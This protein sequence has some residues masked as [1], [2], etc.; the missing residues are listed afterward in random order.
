MTVDKPLMD[1]NKG[2]GNDDSFEAIFA[3]NMGDFVT[4]HL[5]SEDLLSKI[6]HSASQNPE[7]LCKQLEELVTIYSLNNTL[8]L[9]G[10]QS[11]QEFVLY[12]SMAMSLADMLQTDACHIFQTIS[13]D[14][15]EHFLSLTGTSVPGMPKTRWSIG[16]DLSETSLLVVDAYE[17]GYPVVM[18]ELDGTTPGWRPIPELAQEQ[19]RAM[20]AVP[21]QEGQKRNGLILF[22]SYASQDFSQETVDL[23]EAIAKVFVVSLHLQRLLDQAQTFIRQETPQISEMLSLRAQLTETIADLG[24]YQEFFVES[25]ANA[26]DAR[27]N[28]TYGHSQGVAHIAKRIA[29]E[30][31]LSE[32]TTDL[33][34][35]AGLLVSLGRI[36]IPQDILTK[37]ESLTPEERELLKRSPNMGV[38]LLMKMNFL[39]EVIPYVDYQKERWDGKD[40]PHGL[41]GRS[42]PLGARIVAVADAFHAMTQV[43]PYREEPLPPKDA[44]KALQAE[45]G[46]KWDPDVVASMARIVSTASA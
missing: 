46:T 13:K 39:A 37:E 7:R 30:M 3:L 27:N 14:H 26:I 5:I 45:S 33:V 9:L 10:F 17:E 8:S 42:I 22:E 43:R 15:Q 24:R 16:Y 20:I 2:F 21:L 40:S 41:S 25:L 18:N 34:Y 12:D 29:E 19:V 23:A 6:S 31:G 32:K 4:E 28:Y 44:L 38:G 36:H 35:Y 11:T 1:T